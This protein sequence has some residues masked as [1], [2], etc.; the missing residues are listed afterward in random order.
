MGKASDKAKDA[1]SSA[2]RGR[3]ELAGARSVP[4][5][6]AGFPDG[7]VQVWDAQTAERLCE[8]GTVFRGGRLALSP[9]GELCVAAS[10]RKGKRAGIAGYHAVSGAVMWHRPDIRHTQEL[11]F[12]AATGGVWCYIEDGPAL[13]LDPD[14]GAATEALRGVKKVRDGSNGVQQLLQHRNPMVCVLVTSQGRFRIPMIGFAVLDAAFS[15][16]TMCLSEAGGP[17]R[18]FDCASGCELWRYG[19]EAWHV[20]SV[21]YQPVDRLFYAVDFKPREDKG[22]IIRFPAV[23]GEPEEV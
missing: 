15:P 3:I 20:T 7:T 16:E 6:A 19:R 4:R 14:T 8:F 2:H 12:S 17:A 5:I 9:N 13:H 18:C 23:G 11:Y 1:N 10:W 21:W 22:R